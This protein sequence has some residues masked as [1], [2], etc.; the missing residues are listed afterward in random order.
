M[1][2]PGK[3]KDH[4]SQQLG[5]L[6]GEVAIV[7]GAGQGIG[8]AI[9]LRLASD[10]AAVTVADVNEETAGKVAA[11]IVAAGGRSLALRADVTR[12]E[13]VDALVAKT[14]EQL[15]P[16]SI[17]VANAGI[18]QVR[19]FLDITTDDLDRMLAVNVKGALLCVQ[20]AGRAMREQG[21]GRIA[22]AA[23]I[24]GKMASPYQAHYVISKHAVI[25][26]VRS[27][28]VE[29]AP[30]G[31]TVNAYCPGIVDTAMWDLIDRDRGEL[32]GKRPGEL[33]AEMA[34][35]I[36]LGR[37]EQPEDVANLVAFLASPDGGYI[38]GQAINVDGGF[39]MH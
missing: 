25:G 3:E 18:M 1:I 31:I 28:A 34:G 12:P 21:R 23:S 24:A 6:A 37:L 27:A 35:R 5:R 22:V 13:Q 11:E 30:W 33:K 10:G 16:L 14:V 39:I 36:P 4:V 17:M 9:S 7:T 32:L 26:L 15:G 20:A 2:Q 38:T 29:F 8:R 19:R